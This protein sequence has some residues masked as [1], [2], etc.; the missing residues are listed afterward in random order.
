MIEKTSDFSSSSGVRRCTARSPLMLGVSSAVFFVLQ[1]QAIGE[2]SIGT[3]EYLRNHRDI[4]HR[5]TVISTWDVDDRGQVDQI[6]E[7]KDEI[8]RRTPLQVYFLDLFIC[9]IQYTQ[10]GEDVDDTNTLVAEEFWK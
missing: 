5:D 4:V 6:D 3:P 8:I 7:W 9:I 10:L 1:Q 2:T